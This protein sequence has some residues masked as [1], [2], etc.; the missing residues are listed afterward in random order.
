MPYIY[1]IVNDIND[2]IYVG[3][4]LQTIEKRF[5]EHCDD[6]KKIRCEKRP[7][8]DAMNKYGIEHFHIEQI[9]ECSLETINNREIYWINKLNS[10]HNGYNATLGGEGKV[11]VNYKKAYELWLK[12]F[13]L[14]TIAEQLNC[15]AETIKKILVTFNVTDED[16]QKR[17]VETSNKIRPV[18]MLDKETEEVL[19][20]FNSSVEA[21]KYLGDSL[22]SKHILK[23]CRNERK[24]AYGYKW[25]YIDY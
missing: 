2:K 11:R 4:T 9:E 20:I 25:K 21:G 19:M 12:G 15:T 10:Y 5:K 3:K 18:K 16:I 1:K 6:S 7:L 8:Y 14:K 22:K 23:V 17:K 24:T 13:N